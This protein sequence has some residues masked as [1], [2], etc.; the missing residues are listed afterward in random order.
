MST[1]QKKI[2]R[3]NDEVPQEAV[4]KE[5]TCFAIMPI[6]DHP[7]YD[8]GHFGRVYNHLIKPACEKAGFKVVRAD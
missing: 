6:A 1:S 5:K 7:D 4:E 8:N 3:N 2:T